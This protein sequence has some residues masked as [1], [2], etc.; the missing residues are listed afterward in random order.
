MFFTDANMNPFG[1]DVGFDAHAH[2]QCVADAM[3]RAGVQCDRN[4]LKFTPTRRR[5]LEILLAARCALGAY[6][7][8]KVLAAD[9][10]GSQPP[11]AYRAL[12]FL[13]KHGLAHRLDTL[14]AYIACAHLGKSHAPVFLICRACRLVA[15]SPYDPVAG[16]L[17]GSASTAG[18]RIERVVVEAEGLCPECQDTAV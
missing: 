9:G 8:V 18:F 14:N 13:V 7:I 16:C 6:D 10:L 11:V 1:F 15:E 3:T 12:A 5:V 2:G 17:V 4:K